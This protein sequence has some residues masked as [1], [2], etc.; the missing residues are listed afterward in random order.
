MKLVN[1]SCTLFWRELVRDRPSLR[2]MKEIRY[3][4]SAAKC[5]PHINTHG[6]CRFGEMLKWADA[7]TRR[8]LIVSP[9]SQSATHPCFT[10]VRNRLPASHSCTTA[11]TL[12][13]S[14]SLSLCLFL[15]TS[16]SRIFWSIW[17]FRTSP[18]KVNVPV[19]ARLLELLNLIRGQKYYWSRKSN[20]SLNKN[21]KFEL[22][23]EVILKFPQFIE[24]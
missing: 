23:S 11:I 20:Q 21:S 15:S 22:Q 6:G 17:V 8:E 10:R 7:L 24:K 19:V 12:P 14:L 4:G 18:T 1:G 9:R 5:N 3:T 13:F 16:P 2:S